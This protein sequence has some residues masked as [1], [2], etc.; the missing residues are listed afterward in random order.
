LLFQSSKTN[1]SLEV[2]GRT[3]IPFRPHRKNSSH[4]HRQ[5]SDLRF[6]E[7]QF[8]T[9]PFNCRNMKQGLTNKTKQSEEIS[10]NSKNDEYQ[11]SQGIQNTVI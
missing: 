8:K 7:K 3:N 2:T 10:A 9:W 4:L 11:N 5:Q 1:S 6:T